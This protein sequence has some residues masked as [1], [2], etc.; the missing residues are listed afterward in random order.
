MIRALE[1]CFLRSGHWPANSQSTKS[2]TCAPR[3]HSRASRR[4]AR[5]PPPRFRFRTDWS[6]EQHL[7]LVTRLAST[8]VLRERQNADVVAGTHYL[9]QAF[10]MRFDAAYWHVCK[11]RLALTGQGGPLDLRAQQ[12]RP[13]LA[14]YLSREKHICWTSIRER[15][16]LRDEP[17][18]AEAI[19]GVSALLEQPSGYARAKGIKVG[20]RWLRQH[21]LPGTRKHKLRWPA[22]IPRHVFSSCLHDIRLCLLKTHSPLL[23]SW[24]IKTVQAVS[25]QRP[26]YTKLWKHI[27]VCKGTLS[28]DLFNKPPGELDISSKDG[29]QM[30][31]CKYYWKTPFFQTWSCAAKLAESSMRSWLKQFP[32]IVGPLW[33]HHLHCWA[34]SQHR[35]RRADIDH[36][37]SYVEHLKVPQGHVAVPE[38]KDKASCWTMPTEVYQ[39]LFARM[40][41]QDNDHWVRRFVNV[42]DVVENY[43]QAHVDKLPQYL[44]SYCAPARWRRW[45]LAYMY[46]NIKTKCFQSGV[47]R[48]CAKAGHACCR[49]IVS[50]SAHPC[51][52]MYKLN[53]KA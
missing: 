36:H 35:V 49:R 8:F 27:A 52:W 50:W 39:K 24:I 3:K 2:P 12:C 29:L 25:S 9:N 41:N 33:Q 18:G 10:G 6:S 5:R 23:A 15:W 30:K 40:V 44:Q 13:L 16:H 53:A 45:C 11:H 14:C 32:R 26:N 42:A 19:V 17:L 4:C 1:H 7:I 31:L 43:R 51:R 28:T 34:R 46:I 22:I 48:T 37:S 20:D 38:D 47:G 21:G